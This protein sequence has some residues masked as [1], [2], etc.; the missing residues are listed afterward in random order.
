MNWYKKSNNLFKVS[1]VTIE[2]SDSH[3]VYQPMNLSDLHWRLWESMGSTIQRLADQLGVD[4]AREALG[5]LNAYRSRDENYLKLKGGDEE[6]DSAY[7]DYVGIIRCETF[8]PVDADEIAEMIDKWTDSMELVDDFYITWTRS[9]YKSTNT[10]QIEWLKNYQIDSTK[11]TEWRIVV[12]KNPSVNAPLIPSL[13][14]ANGNWEILHRMLMPDREFEYSGI[15]GLDE[16]ESRIEAAKDRFKNSPKNYVEPFTDSHNLEIP[17][18]ADPEERKRIIREQAENRNRIRI[19][20]FG[21][22]A[23][24]V[25]HYFRDLEEIAEYCRKHGVSSVRW[26]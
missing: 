24:R 21:L 18:D 20:D 10:K 9:P 19:Y 3:K 4:K 2:P 22:P 15:M 6:G 13:N 11:G 5:T 16:L 8:E 17:E 7:G 14:V 12:H 26:G 25:R 1:S 23:E